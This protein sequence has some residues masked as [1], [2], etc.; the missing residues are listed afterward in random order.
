MARG[1]K[2]KGV[3]VQVDVYVAGR[4]VPLHLVAELVAGLVLLAAV[5][6]FEVGRWTL[7]RPRRGRRAVDVLGPPEFVP[8]RDSSPFVE[9]S[10]DVQGRDLTGR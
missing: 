7:R 4:V 1:R 6:G 9:K 2:F 5:L 10:A 3:R 8:G